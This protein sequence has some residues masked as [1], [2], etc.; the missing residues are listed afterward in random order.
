M[1]K[2]I[3]ELQSRNSRNK[4]RKQRFEDIHIV[5]KQLRPYVV[6]L[7][8]LSLFEN[9]KSISKT[10]YN[11]IDYGEV[12]LNLLKNDYEKCL[13]KFENISPETPLVKIIY[14][15]EQQISEAYAEVDLSYYEINKSIVVK[16]WIDVFNSSLYSFDFGIIYSDINENLKIGILKCFQKILDHFGFYYVL[17]EDFS[18]KILMDLE[19]EIDYLKE[20]EDYENKQKLFN[21]DFENS[22]KRIN[23]TLKDLKKILKKKFNKNLEYKNEILQNLHNNI[24]YILDFDMNM[25]SA[26]RKENYYNDVM[27]F[28]MMF[29]PSFKVDDFSVKLFE[30]MEQSR[31]EE[32]NNF[33]VE[34]L[35][36]YHTVTKDTFKTYA[37]ES[38]ND[39]KV[40]EENLNEIMYYINKI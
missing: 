29:V 18:D 16:E 31:L 10:Y 27:S 26:L 1:F 34:L 14:D 24:S 21:K 7:E 25:I 4:N 36:T 30:L 13:S 6:N 17:N 33:G 38:I 37:E 11:L 12:M 39:I 15:L 9:K 20:D 19:G 3:N 8:S 5:A 32:M 40:F 35:C 28:E 23:K 2:A 22:F